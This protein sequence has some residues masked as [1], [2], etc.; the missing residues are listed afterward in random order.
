MKLLNEEYDN[1]KFK[2]KSLVDKLEL[3]LK[4]IR[5]NE[6]DLRERYIEL[7]KSWNAMLEDPDQIKRQL[8]YNV[9]R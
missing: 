1:E 8:S 6:N 3:E 5:Y 9:I 4:T 7:N 2:M